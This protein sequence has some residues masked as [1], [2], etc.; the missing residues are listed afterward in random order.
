M[1]DA[2]ED[3]GPDCAEIALTLISAADSHD[4]DSLMPVEDPQEAL[5]EG[6][7]ARTSTG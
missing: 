4:T 6:S 3:E 5:N 7:L 1:T 2:F